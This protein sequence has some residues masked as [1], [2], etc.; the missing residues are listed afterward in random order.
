MP[1]RKKTINRI[2]GKLHGCT[3][4]AAAVKTA[5]TIPPGVSVLCDQARYTMPKVTGTATIAYILKSRGGVR[6]ERLLLTSKADVEVYSTTKSGKQGVRSL[7]G[8]RVWQHPFADTHRAH[9]GYLLANSS[10]LVP[11]YSIDSLSN[12]ERWI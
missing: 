6:E 8:C 11:F 5:A 9:H 4:C 10:H 2:K 1:A 3:A 12:Q 7:Q